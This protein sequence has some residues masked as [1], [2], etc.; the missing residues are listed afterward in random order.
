[1]ANR[2]TIKETTISVGDMIKIH[3]QFRE[4]EKIKTQIFR[5]I[6]MAIR[7]SGK[8]RMITVRKQSK[9]KIGVERIFSVNS[10]FLKKVE[11]IKKGRVRRAKIYF[12]REMSESEIRRRIF[13][14]R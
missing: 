5:G 1:M 8:N 3:Y 2:V 4:G 11:L 13:K 9:A 10:P 14:K 6:L 12:I 7:G